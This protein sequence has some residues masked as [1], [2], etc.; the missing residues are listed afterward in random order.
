MHPILLSAGPITIYSYGAMVAIGFALATFLIHRNA[1]R[2]GFDKEKMVD[3]L[4][5][6]L[7][8]GIL[9][10][11][12]LYILINIDYYSAHPVEIFDL[13][14]GGLVWY[15]GFI[16][17]VI[18]LIVYTRITKTNLWDICDLIVPYVAM[19]QGFGRIGCFL[20]GCC[21]G[22]E[23]PR[24]FYPTV[25][26]PLESIC[27]MPT[28][29][30]SAIALFAIFALLWRW[31][32]HRHF[33]GEIFLGYCLLYSIKRFFMEFLRGDNPRLSFGLTMSQYI[34]LALFIFAAVFFIRKAMQWQKKNLP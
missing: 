3:I 12:S 18:T 13:S 22:P 14:R 33:L 23:V 5:L 20:N 34:S 21:Y 11:R 17:S 15:G 19:A 10:A 28:Q 27:R 4:I 8:T 16:A 31:Q 30:Y 1:P 25:S 32:R 24:G 2:F 29:L 6:I 9:G 26:F 7:V